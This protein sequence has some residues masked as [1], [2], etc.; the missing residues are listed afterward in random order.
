MHTRRNC[1]SSKPN[2]HMQQ[3]ST[4][5]T[6]RSR[7]RTLVSALSGGHGRYTVHA[8][9]DKK[10][11]MGIHSTWGGARWWRHS[12]RSVQK[13][14]PRGSVTCT[15]RRPRKGYIATGGIGPA[16]RSRRAPVGPPICCTR[17]R[18]AAAR[19]GRDQQRP[20]R[21]R[22]ARRA[23]QRGST[24]AR[25]RRSRRP[26]LRRTRRGAAA[27]RRMPPRRPASRRPVSRRPALPRSTRPAAP[28]ATRADKGGATARAPAPPRRPPRPEAGGSRTTHA[29]RRRRRHRTRPA[30]K[31]GGKRSRRP[32]R[33]AWGA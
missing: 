13:T 20:A 31:R 24:A 8:S 12:A 19:K 16:R 18:A 2:W 7:Q 28:R 6:E 27:S 1:K 21:R 22:G 11:C 30:R 9:R 33:Q 14:G 23:R 17:A 29:T 5:K 32:R 26:R 10:D 4:S 25:L 3:D 15:R